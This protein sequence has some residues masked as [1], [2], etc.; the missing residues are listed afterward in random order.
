MVFFF[1]LLSSDSIFVCTYNHKKKKKKK[2]ATHWALSKVSKVH[3]TNGSICLECCLEGT[4]K[5][6]SLQIDG[7]RGESIQKTGNESS[8]GRKYIKL[9]I[10]LYMYMFI[11][12][13]TYKLYQN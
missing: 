2:R 1:S 9:Y 10:Y 11:Y 12:T 3:T 5:L 8:D 13:Y 4:L 7:M 6:C